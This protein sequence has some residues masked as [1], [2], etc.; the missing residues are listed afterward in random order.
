MPRHGAQLQ[1]TNLA[2]EASEGAASLRVSR[3][4]FSSLIA[5]MAGDVRD[6]FSAYR[7]VTA[8]QVSRKDSSRF[9]KD[10]KEAVVTM[11]YKGSAEQA[12]MALDGSRVKNREV[13]I[14]YIPNKCTVLVEHLGPYVTNQILKD[15]F[16]QF[17][18]VKKAVVKTDGQKRS[19]GLGHVVFEDRARA[20]SCVEK[21][22]E[23]MFILQGSARPVSVSLLEPEDDVEGL[24]Y[25][26][27]IEDTAYSWE[28]TCEPHFGKANTLEYE[29]AAKW[30]E[31]ERALSV[32]REELERLHSVE[33]ENLYRMQKE[34]YVAETE[35]MQQEQMKQEQMRQEQ[36][37]QELLRAAEQQRQ[38]QQMQQDQM[39]QKQ[40]MLMQQQQQL[41]Q[42][43]LQVIPPFNCYFPY[44][45]SS[46]ASGMWGV[47]V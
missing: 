22:A 9:T 24:C 5:C 46:I 19:K 4:G 31:V 27:L 43:K 18:E 17:G 28:K 8:V 32:Q 37:R 16:T 47:M 7:D 15:A 34:I 44:R 29:W 20:I 38:A 1:V 26:D 33:R 30:V 2:P 11:R 41:Q 6:L 25:R 39:R 14:H 13:R 23:H 36:L 10:Q 45:V 35:R 21:C 40:Q 42:P 12:M 3:S